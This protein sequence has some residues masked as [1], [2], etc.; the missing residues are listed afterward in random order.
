MCFIN[1][2]ARDQ[3][4]EEYLCTKT[5]SRY[6]QSKKCL[7]ILLLKLDA[8]LKSCVKYKKA[9]VTLTKACCTEY[10]SCESLKTAHVTTEDCADL[11]LYRSAV[12]MIGLRCDHKRCNH[13]HNVFTC[14]CCTNVAFRYQL[15][16]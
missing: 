7:N 15:L 13:T 1:S 12:S 8:S 3:I 10:C 4:H 9:I 14:I 11:L 2:F 6:S 5:Y 16:L